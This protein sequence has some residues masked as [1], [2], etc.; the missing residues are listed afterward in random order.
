MANQNTIMGWLPKDAANRAAQAVHGL[1][2]LTI[3]VHRHRN[4]IESY[5][6]KTGETLKII[7]ASTDQ[8]NRVYYDGL[9]KVFESMLIAANPN[10]LRIVEIDR[11]WQLFLERYNMQTGQLRANLLDLVECFNLE[12]ISRHLQE[13][14]FYILRLPRSSELVVTTIY[15]G[16]KA[17]LFIPPRLLLLDLLL[18]LSHANACHKWLS[19]GIGMGGGKDTSNVHARLDSYVRQVLILGPTVC[20]AVLHDYG[21]LVVGISKDRSKRGGLR[22]MLSLGLTEKL[23]HFNED[24]PLACGHSPQ[25]RSNDIADMLALTQ[26][27]NRLVHNDGRINAWH[28]FTLDL[29]HSAWN[30]TDRVGPFKECASYGTPETFIGY[31]WGLAE[32]CAVTVLDAIDSI[33]RAVFRDESARWVKIPRF[34]NGRID[35]NEVANRESYVRPTIP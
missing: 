21:N 3:D 14:S 30:F 28:A 23:S 33:N 9:R 25:P 15:G 5:T 12:E 27:R 22:R 8:D 2:A 18:M 4:F 6:E 32:F 31:E 19:N 20:E 26:I 7:N 13:D 11:I 34:A 35:F 1:A 10:W 24:W 17:D 16:L 29:I